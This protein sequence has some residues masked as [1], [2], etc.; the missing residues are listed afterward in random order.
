MILNIA[1]KSATKED[2]QLQGIQ[3]SLILEA[4]LPLGCKWGIQYL[5]S[6]YEEKNVSYVKTT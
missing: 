2:K 6:D 1:E 4:N 3:V 5:N